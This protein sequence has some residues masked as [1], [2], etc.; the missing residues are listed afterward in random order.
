MDA[1]TIESVTTGVI[2][3]FAIWAIFMVYKLAVVIIRAVFRRR[4]ARIS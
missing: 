1:A 3:M 4:A 2:F